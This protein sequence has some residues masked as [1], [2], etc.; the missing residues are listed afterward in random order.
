MQSRS[1]RFCQHLVVAIGLITALPGYV[2][3]EKGPKSGPSPKAEKAPQATAQQT[4]ALN[5]LL[6]GFRFGMNKDAVIAVISKQLD[7]LYAERIKATTDIATQDRLRKEKKGELMRVTASYVEFSGTATPWDASLIGGEFAHNSREAML[8]R[9]ENEGGKNQRR[10][11][12][13]SNGKLWKIF[14]GVDVTSDTGVI[15]GFTAFRAR[16]Q[17]RFGTGK[18]SGN[19]VIWYAANLE[20]QATDLSKDYG[21]FG[22]AILDSAMASRFK[23]CAENRLRS[24]KSMSLIA[25]LNLQKIRLRTE[26]TPH[27]AASQIPELRY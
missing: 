3:A 16:L 5:E 1:G 21:T 6:A 14:L 25:L 27:P 24:D 12:F 11:F 22:L 4:M 2:L 20:A 17:D 23:P 19:K 8:W 26:S 15:P 13:F 9:W 18:V 7:Q 10:F